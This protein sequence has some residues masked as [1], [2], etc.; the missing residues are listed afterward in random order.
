MSLINTPAACSSA[1]STGAECYDYQRRNIF[2]LSFKTSALSA[3]TR[4]AH[5]S[6]KPYCGEPLPTWTCHLVP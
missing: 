3:S 4:L 2:P 1:T 5:I 6:P